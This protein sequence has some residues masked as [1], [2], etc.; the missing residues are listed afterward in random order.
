MHNLPHTPLVATMRVL[1]S[2]GLLFTYPVQMFPVFQII[3]NTA[4]GNSSPNFLQTVQT[5]A[6][7]SS[8]DPLRSC[9]CDSLS[10]RFQ[11]PSLCSLGTTSDSSRR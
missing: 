6:P 2:L 7:V 10:L 8:R 3:Q 1:Y 4:F 11:R 5:G 9:P